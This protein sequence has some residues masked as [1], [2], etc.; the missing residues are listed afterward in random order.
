MGTEPRSET[1]QTTQEKTT[2]RTDGDGVSDRVSLLPE[3]PQTATPATPETPRAACA[4]PEGRAVKR[5][6]RDYDAARRARTD[7]AIH[8]LSA[9]ACNLI[10]LGLVLWS[11]YALQ[12]SFLAG[13]YLSCQVVFTAAFR[14]L[15]LK[16]K[17]RAEKYGGGFV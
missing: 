1:G 14:R 5:V 3:A 2:A 11:V 13:L 6:E 15:A 16:A 7:E 12:D 8:L 17:Q 10:F 4:D 9:L